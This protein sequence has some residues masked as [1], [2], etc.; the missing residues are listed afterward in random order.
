MQADIHR[1]DILASQQFTKI[2][3]YIGNAVTACHA[4]SMLPVDIGNRHH[5]NIRDGLVIIQVD[6]SDL[7]HANQAYAYFF[8]HGL[9]LIRQ[10][11]LKK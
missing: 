7:A 6:L 11:R 9:L 5:F 2:G 10:L 1:L 8:V 3:V 4:L